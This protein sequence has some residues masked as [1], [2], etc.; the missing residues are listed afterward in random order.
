M[1]MRTNQSLRAW[2]IC[3][4]ANPGTTNRTISDFTMAEGGYSDLELRVAAENDAISVVLPSED[5][6]ELQ[7]IH[8]R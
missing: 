4:Q 1:R 7:E 5:S 2:G 6:A 8:A 3:R